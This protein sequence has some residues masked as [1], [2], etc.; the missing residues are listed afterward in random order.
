MAEI[1]HFLLGN[2]FFIGAHS[3]YQYL[4][5]IDLRTFI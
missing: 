4:A 3:R 5:K 2:C 1:Q